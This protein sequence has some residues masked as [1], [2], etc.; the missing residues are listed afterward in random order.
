MIPEIDLVLPP[1][2]DL[3]ADLRQGQHHLDLTGPVLDL[4]EHQFAGDPVEHHAPGDPDRLAGAGVGFEIGES[5][6][7]RPDHVVA[8]EVHRVRI[9][10]AFTHLVELLPADQLLLGQPAGR[11]RDL[12]SVLLGQLLGDR[13]PQRDRRNIDAV[14]QRL[15]CATGERTAGLLDEPLSQPCRDPHSR[16][17][18]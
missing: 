10:A 4:G 13:P 9:E 2:E 6:P 5:L 8:L 15:A 17:I 1:V 7:D 12:F 11:D 16:Q 3:L 14:G 18:A